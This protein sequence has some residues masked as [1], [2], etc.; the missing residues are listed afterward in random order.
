[1]AKTQEID[2]FFLFNLNTNHTKTSANMTC[3]NTQKKRHQK[4]PYEAPSGDKNTQKK[5]KIVKKTTK[6]NKILKPCQG[7]VT[8]CMTLI[9]HQMLTTTT[10]TKLK[11]KPP[12]LQLLMKLI[13]LMLTKLPPVIG[14]LLN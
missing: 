12:S 10:S 14:K 2:A 1:M 13:F 5:M 4:S 11:K 9:L 7:Y 6:A 3:T 8:F